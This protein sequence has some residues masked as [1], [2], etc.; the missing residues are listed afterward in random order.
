MTEA[1]K[2]RIE[3]EAR[4]SA[5][6]KSPAD[7]TPAGIEHTL[8][9]LRVHQIELEMQNEELR[10]SQA[11]LHVAH[12]RYFDLYDMAPVGYVTI[13]KNGMIIEAN[14][15]ATTLLGVTRRALVSMP[16]SKFIFPED[17]DVYYFHLKAL[18]DAFVAEP[19]HPEKPD[20]FE[21]RMLNPLHNHF[22]ACLDCM[23]LMGSDHQ[24]TCRIALSDI[25]PRK[26]AAIALN[27]SLREKE[28]M[29]KEIHHR[30]KNNLQIISSLLHL[31]S[32][33]IENPVTKEVLLDMQNRVKS[34]AIIHEHLYVSNN[35]NAVDLEVYLTQLC[36]KLFRSM[37]DGSG[38]IHLTLNLSP[39]HLEIDKAI[40]CGLL[41]NELVTN[42]FKHAFP[43]NR[44]GELL[45][46]LLPLEHI[47]GWRIRVADNGIGLPA[48]F[49]LDHVR[50]LG[51]KLVADL[52]RQ[53]G[54]KLHIAPG[55]GTVFA[56]EF[57]SQFEGPSE[58]FLTKAPS[59]ASYH[60]HSSPES[61]RHPFDP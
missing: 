10:Q 3:A 34:M 6:P 38:K 27:Q 30:V 12:E 42:T 46:E 20:A 23:T 24:P 26:Q 1:T 58:S 15:T 11:A 47:P 54:G 17:Q 18:F 29:L 44:C 60:W 14:L 45:V 4:L 25:T 61:G 32:N 33:Q 59:A 39:V 50:S 35:F 13:S 9:E 56:F 19:D 7:L 2:L 36:N 53:L 55:P 49:S 31:Q 52:T 51:L 43:E 16:F 28:S 5:I 40:P 37:T 41:V 22:W 21:V 8:H 57:P 48:G